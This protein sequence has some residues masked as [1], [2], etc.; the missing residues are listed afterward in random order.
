MKT[1]LTVVPSYKNMLSPEA[2]KAYIY[3]YF[4]IYLLCITLCFLLLQSYPILNS[5]PKYA[6]R[7]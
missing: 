5:L 2:R 7:I 1:I 6:E 3:I 4:Y